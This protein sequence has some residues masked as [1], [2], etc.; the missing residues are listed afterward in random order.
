[1]EG[2]D[3][4]ADDYL[5]KPFSARELVARVNMSLEMARLRRE[6]TRELQESEARFRNMAE[7][8]PVMMWMTDQTGSL[9]YLNP[10]WSEFTGQAQE[11]ALGSAHGKPC[12]PK[13]ASN[14]SEFSSMPTPRASLF[15][16]SIVCGARTEAIAGH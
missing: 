10:L 3:A 16:S 4:G 15:A 8:A 1:M 7:H 9:T 14:R 2:L 12:I 11:E 5:I 6:A 13:I